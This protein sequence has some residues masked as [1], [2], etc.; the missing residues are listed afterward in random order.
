MANSLEAKRKREEEE[1]EEEERR[2]RVRVRIH[3]RKCKDK[4]EGAG[5]PVDKEA[6][7][8]R[9]ISLYLRSVPTALLSSFQLMA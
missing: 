9:L 4:V 5:S 2:G 7:T 8:T 6:L 1:E 3:T